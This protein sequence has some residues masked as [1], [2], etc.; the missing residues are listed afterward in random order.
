MIL[1]YNS[2]KMKITALEEY[3]LRCMLLLARRSA[4]SPVTLPEIS[5]NEGITLPYAGKLLMILRKG[6]LVKAVRGRNGGYILTRPAD[7]TSLRDIFTALGEPVGG[8]R[9]C[10]RYTK[11]KSP[12]IHEE[13]CSIKDVWGAFAQFINEYSQGITLADLVN[14]KSNSEG[15]PLKTAKI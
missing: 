5:D 15:A 13:D 9:H 2:W 7:L 14:G 12:C 3:G 1:E 8:A 6:G 10:G 11:E 4:A